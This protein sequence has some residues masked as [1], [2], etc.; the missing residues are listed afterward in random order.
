[1]YTPF[2]TLNSLVAANNLSKVIPIFA[3]YNTMA[4]FIDLVADYDSWQQAFG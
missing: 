2:V 1:L 3:F 4:D